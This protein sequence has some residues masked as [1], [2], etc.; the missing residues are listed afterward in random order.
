[1]HHFSYAQ[2]RLHAEDVPLDAIADQVGTPVYVYSAATLTRHYQVFSGAFAGMKATVCYAMK[3]NSNGAVLR[4]LAQLGAGADVVSGGE[5]ALA[6][7]A[8]FPP[9]KIVFS[10]VGKTRAEL[11]AALTAGIHQIN[12]ESVPELEALNAVAMEMGQRAPIALRVN[13]D[14]GAGGHDKITTGRKEDKFGIE[15]TAAH[16]IYQQAAR[17][18]GILVQ[19][20]AIHIGSQIAD[21][22]P[23]EQAFLRVRD[24]HAMLK[25]D[26]IEITHLDLGGG[27]GVP[28]EDGTGTP[29]PPTAYA[30]VVRQTLGDL[31]CA[32]TFEPG[33]LIVGNA[34]V[35]LTEVV[36]VKEGSTR[37]FAVV[38]AAMNDLMR[39]A[40]YEAYHHI[41]TVREPAAGQETQPYDVVGPVC[42]TGDTFGKGRHLPPLQA[43]DRLAFATAGAY[44]SSMSSTYN[45]RP[46][47]PEVMVNG[48]QWAVVRRRPSI[49]EL[50]ALE[51]TPEWLE[52]QSG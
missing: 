47:V 28:Y 32:L 18:P 51:Q 50:V 7:R 23:F 12:V 10:G 40:L 52:N 20:I 22:T 27:L 21:L 44:G 38:D 15:W 4:T 2:G 48:A 30:E 29:P 1:M 25:K 31:G 6:L 49:E 19:G 24:L 8:G 3:A 39:P 46:L 37:T 9:E 36:Y 42:E 13:P 34:G 41:L 33:R 5:L 17:M 43:G 45:A 16:G 11:I 35:L 14:V 26:G